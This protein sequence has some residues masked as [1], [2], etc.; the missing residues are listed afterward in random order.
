MVPTPR[1]AARAAAGAPVA[2]QSPIL[3]LFAAVRSQNGWPRS[4]SPPRD[5][6]VCLDPPRREAARRRRFR[7]PELQAS[8]ACAGATASRRLRTSLLSWCGGRPCPPPPLPRRRPQQKYAPGTRLCQCCEP[9]CPDALRTPSGKWRAERPA[10]SWPRSKGPGGSCL[11]P[12][13]PLSAGDRGDPRPHARA[14]SHIHSH[15]FALKHTSPE[16]GCG[17]GAPA[18]SEDRAVAVRS[19]TGS[20]ARTLGGELLGLG[21]IMGPGER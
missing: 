19:G 18:R 6:G 2:S 9:G 8:W 17:E 16:L 15:T 3:A 11:S 12:P 21:R 4:A 5:C 20:R 13:E 7:P 1:T 10:R 14:R